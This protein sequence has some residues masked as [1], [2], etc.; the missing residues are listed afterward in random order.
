MLLL[1]LL[2]LLLLQGIQLVFEIALL[3]RHLG[4]VP[5]PLLGLIVDRKQ[6]LIVEIVVVVLV[7]VVLI[8]VVII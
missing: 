4:G 8:V 3:P 5:L 6:I 2:L 7:V 1:L